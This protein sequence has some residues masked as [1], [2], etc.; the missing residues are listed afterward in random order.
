MLASAALHGSGLIH[1]VMPWWVAN[2]AMIALGAVT[3]SRFA[4]TP[5]RLLAK[6][7]ARRSARSRWRWRSPR[8]F[9]AVAGQR[10]VA[11]ASPR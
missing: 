11:A 8:V 3:G 6:F 1:A 9:A 4:N 2:T 5:L 7:S 10:A